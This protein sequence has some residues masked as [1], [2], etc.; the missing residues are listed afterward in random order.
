VVEGMTLDTLSKVKDRFT[1]PEL[2]EIL[3]V[4]FDEFI[5]AFEQKILESIPALAEIDPSFVPQKEEEDND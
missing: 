2:T 5:D 4:S 1:V 3:E